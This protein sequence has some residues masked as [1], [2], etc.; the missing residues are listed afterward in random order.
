MSGVSSVSWI[1]RVSIVNWLRL[2]S[3][4]S[5]VSWMSRSDYV[6]IVKFKSQKVWSRSV[7]I[8]GNGKGKTLR[9]GGFHPPPPFQLK[10]GKVKFLPILVNFYLTSH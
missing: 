9:R 8:C 1:S 10:K 3:W 7:D 2:V 5:K 4:V 6:S